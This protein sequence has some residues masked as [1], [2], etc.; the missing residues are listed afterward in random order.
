MSERPSCVRS[1]PAPPCTSWWP[2]TGASRRS[3]TPSRSPR[4]AAPS[5][6]PPAACSAWPRATSPGCPSST[7]SWPGTRT[8]S[9]P[10]WPRWWPPGNRRK[11]WSRGRTTPTRITPCWGWPRAAPWPGRASGCSPTPS[12]S[13]TGPGS[14]PATCGGVGVPSWCAPTATGLASG[15]AVA[16]YPSQ[17]AAHDDDPEGLKPSFLPELRRTLRDVLR[18]RRHRGGRFDLSA[19][20][21]TRAGALRRRPGRCAGGWCCASGPCRTAAARACRR[22]PRPPRTARWAS[23]TTACRSSTG[24]PP[25][26]RS[27]GWSGPPRRGSP[28]R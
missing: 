15:Q 27:A 16:A 3:G 22:W 20:P 28:P 23:T 25:C 17:M 5:C 1:T 2:P 8:R 4:C 6:G 7:P 13:S 9:P 12:G 26:R 18:G 10:P 11:C 24:P 19:G 21:P 14:W